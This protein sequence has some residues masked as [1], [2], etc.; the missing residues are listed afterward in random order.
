MIYPSSFEEKIGFNQ[1]RN[2]IGELCS[3]EPAKDWIVT[4][5]FSSSF[6]EVMSK[7]L[8]VS[9]MLK[10]LE[11]NDNLPIEGLG[12]PRPLLESIKIQGSFLQPGELLSIRR[13]LGV[14]AEVISFF[15]RHRNPEGVPTYPSLA[16]I[17]DPLLPFPKIIKNIDSIIDKYGNIADNASTELS[18]IRR[19]LL[20]VNGTVNSTL[21]KVLSRAAAEGIVDAD[22]TPT[23]RD[24]RLVIPVPP[25]N[26]RRIPGIVHDESASGKT[27]FI[28]PSEVVEINNRIRELQLEERREIQRILVEIAD[29]IRPE[30]EGILNSVYVVG[31]LDFIRAKAK[32]SIQ[33]EAKMPVVEDHPELDWYHACNPCLLIALQKQNRQIVP[34]DIRLTPEKRILVIS[35]P[36]AGGKSVCLKT[37][38]LIQY[39]LQSGLLPPLYENSH[40][41]IFSDIFVDIGDDQSIEDDLSTYS[42]HLRSMKFFVAKGGKKSLFLIDEFGGGT[43]P[44]I[45]GAI[46]Q[47][48]L[49]KFNELGMWGIV[50]THYQNLKQY[51]EA[52][53]G[54]VNGSMLYDRHLMQPLFRLSIGSPGSSF[55]I[56]IARKTGLPKDIL[57]E[58]ESIVGSDYVNLD[59]YLLDIARDRKYWEN[60]RQQ[61]RVK[62]KKIE[63]T[64]QRYESDSETL[65]LKRNELIEDARKEAKRIIDESNSLIE[66]TIKE[67]KE[68][69]AE[70]ARTSKARKE[71][72]EKKTNLTEQHK[73]SEHPLLRLKN[74]KIRKTPEHTIKSEL[75]DIKVGDIVKLDGEGSPGK[76]LEINGKN[77]I[78]LFGMLKTNVSIDRLRKTDAKIKPASTAKSSF[79]TS[80][81]VDG[82]RERQLSFSRELDVR[83]MRVD[84]AIQAV[85]YFIDDAIQFSADRVRILH[86]TGTGALRQAIRQYLDSIRGVK[87]FHDEHVQFGGAGITVINFV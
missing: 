7:L 46:A 34:L 14:I 70:K 75:T 6:E 52:T 57:L 10:I 65:R 68:S 86:G 5:Q 82:M 66:R 32:Y 63:D 28:E 27:V 50:T 39:M 49:H 56:E 23:V 35:G 40:M 87:S 1:I 81:T 37:V 71:L 24:G 73:V 83:G 74:K 38:G 64:L 26:K 72:V 15:A 59:K 55:A 48:I 25:M 16:L 47:A 12:N 80:S 77:A 69:Q 20:S 30:I 84:E 58:A 41:G 51:A 22:T 33:I 21:R 11:R 19:S 78:V 54:L 53:N 62:E 17:A 31:H 42:S 60:K 45:G 18:R 29:V 9:E 36:N 85:T 79:L 44:Q 13:T 61:I 3:S 43:E 8:P 2:A 76:I 4:M 67:I